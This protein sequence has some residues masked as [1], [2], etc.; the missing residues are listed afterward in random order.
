MTVVRMNAVV[1]QGRPVFTI[2]HAQI[3][4]SRDEE[5]ANLEVVAEGRIEQGA[6][7]PRSARLKDRASA[8]E[9]LHEFQAAPYSSLVQRIQAIHQ[10]VRIGAPVFLLACSARVKYLKPSCCQPA[11]S[12]PTSARRPPSCPSRWLC[13]SRALPAMRGVSRAC[14]DRYHG[15][16]T[17]SW[18]QTMNPAISIMVLPWALRKPMQRDMTSSG[19]FR[20]NRRSCLG[21]RT[22]QQ[23]QSGSCSG[24]C[25]SICDKRRPVSHQYQLRFCLQ[26]VLHWQGRQDPL[27]CTN[28]YRFGCLPWQVTW[29]MVCSGAL[30]LR[31]AGGG[32]LQA[33]GPGC[34]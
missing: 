20:S 14:S 25:R 4:S 11:R 32:G 17:L 30:L 19:R 2:H 26:C 12:C 1:T 7:P 24:H 27:L 31:G 18:C 16:D 21:A 15:P 9:R 28:R 22:Q 29:F 13:S 8:Q 10:R 33:G 3:C 34:P 5:K 23:R 6:G